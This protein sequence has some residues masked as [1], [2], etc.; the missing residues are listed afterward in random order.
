MYAWVSDR[1]SISEACRNL[2]V[3]QVDA[4]EMLARL[5]LKAIE[6]A[7]KLKL[8][9]SGGNRGL[10]TDHSRRLFWKAIFMVVV[11]SWEEIATA[12]VPVMKQLVAEEK[13]EMRDRSLFTQQM[14]G[15]K[16]RKKNDVNPVDAETG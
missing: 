3:G 2:G 14:S 15:R 11:A 9:N 13:K 10:K 8:T 5:M 12:A 6:S 1:D 16:R 4:S 7:D